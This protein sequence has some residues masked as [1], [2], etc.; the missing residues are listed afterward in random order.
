GIGS[1]AWDRL[2]GT[3]RPRDL[4][5]FREI[6][7]SHHAV[8]TPGDLLFHIRATRMPLCVHLAAQ[9]MKRL[10]GAVEIV[11]EV[12]GFTYFDGRE[13]I[14]FVDGTENPVDAA[15]VAAT[16]I[17]EEDPD[18]AG[19]SYV[20]VQKYLHDLAAWN[21]VPVAEQERIIGREKLSD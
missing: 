1:D 3:P 13:L 18:F 20:I 7:G 4:H 10:G 2:F 8:A 14:G 9:I 21:R 12:H 5:P 6:R 17:G 11:D 15:A 19:G 16:I